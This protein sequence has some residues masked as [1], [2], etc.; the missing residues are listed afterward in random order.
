MSDLDFDT[1]AIVT[2]VGTALLAVSRPPRRWLIGLGIRLASILVF[3]VGAVGLDA[4]VDG[5]AR[6]A[7]IVA[8]VAL[9]VGEVAVRILDGNR[10]GIP[11][12]V[13]GAGA[14]A[15]AGFVD[16]VEISAAVTVA[17]AGLMLLVAVATRRTG[18]VTAPGAVLLAVDGLAGYDH[19][20]LDVSFD[21][22]GLGV[23]AVALLAAVLGRDDGLDPDD[24]VT[25][26][27]GA[28]I[29]P[30]A[31]TGFVAALVLVA[32]DLSHLRSAGL[33]LAGGATLA[34]AARHPAG[35]VAL[36]PGVAAALGAA[37]QADHPVHAVAGGA[38]LLL[39][40]AASSWPTDSAGVVDVRR[41]WALPLA[42]LFAVVPLWGWSEAEV[43]RGYGAAVA[44][45]AAVIGLA[46]FVAV[47]DHAR[48]DQSS[49][50]TAGSLIR[51]R[52]PAAR[53]T[54]GPTLPTLPHEP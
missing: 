48:R 26:G 50:P 21:R 24:L 22:V 53:P 42:G 14:L 54:D 3:L 41:H 25:D 16:D 31:L 13:L 15:G 7:V 47:A 27:K 38:V 8:V 43:G 2:A 34:A 32:Q 6:T 18:V 33:L 9:V 52:P 17:G 28:S 40:L 19:S 45:A 36:V 4:E 39:V 51:R 46:G 20:A 35:V 12:L 5:D 1:L 11:A 30:M 44:V 10:R 23:A 49:R 37:G 29:P